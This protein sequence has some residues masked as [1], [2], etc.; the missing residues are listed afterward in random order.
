MAQEFNNDEPEEIIITG[1]GKENTSSDGKGTKEGSGN[2]SDSDGG[3]A[4]VDKDAPEEGDKKEGGEGEEDGEGQK[5]DGDAKDGGEG[6]DG[7]PKP[8]DEDDEDGEEEDDETIEEV[9]CAIL[10]GSEKGVIGKIKKEDI[11]S[12]NREIEVSYDHTSSE[13]GEDWSV[14]RRP[15]RKIILLND[16][17]AY[18]KSNDGNVIYV[19]KVMGFTN[20]NDIER[21]Q[22]YLSVY[23]PITT[24]YDTMFVY[25]SNILHKMPNCAVIS[26]GYKGRVGCFYEGDIDDIGFQKVELFE[27][28]GGE[29]R[30]S[31]SKSIVAYLDRVEF[32]TFGDKV[33]VSRESRDFKGVIEN[34]F[35]SWGIPS[36]CD[37]VGDNYVWFA[38]NDFNS[39]L[40]E[41][42]KDIT[43]VDLSNEGQGVFESLTIQIIEDIISQFKEKGTFPSERENFL[44]CH[45]PKAIR[46]SVN[47]LDTANGMD[48]QRLEIEIKTT[49]ETIIEFDREVAKTLLRHIQSSGYN[50]DPI[51]GFGSIFYDCLK[52]LGVF[53]MVNTALVQDN[54]NVVSIYRDKNKLF[55]YSTIGYIFME[56]IIFGDRKNITKFALWQNERAERIDALYSLLNFLVGTSRDKESYKD[57]VKYPEINEEV[58][59]IFLLQLKAFEDAI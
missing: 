31:A 20:V 11:K 59:R 47:L 46:K 38:H 28:T 30:G 40:W 29:W 5:N 41:M 44:Y 2:D 13:D 8:K 7:E 42:V 55:F 36:N 53:N 26:G 23:N 50:F 15:L 19:G 17:V 25:V 35:I 52:E 16:Y 24:E 34:R 22:L 21:N 57:V 51:Y 12:E 56:E 33:T 14:A 49:M 58:G 4:K 48:K 32:V 6:E 45:L 39:H 18:K 54:M 9:D 43:E 27:N 10:D 1:D 37:G 3:G